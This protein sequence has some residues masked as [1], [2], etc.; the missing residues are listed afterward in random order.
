MMKP[1]FC[2]SPIF[3]NLLID[4]KIMHIVI[5]A[6]KYIKNNLPVTQLYGI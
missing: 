3:C 5:S 1:S 4:K 2:D 6:C